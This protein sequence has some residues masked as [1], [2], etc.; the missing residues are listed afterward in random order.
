MSKI[1]WRKVAME[2]RDKLWLLGAAENQRR[3]HCE[4]LLKRELLAMFHAQ[5]IE[6]RSYEEK[7]DGI[8]KEVARRIYE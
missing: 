1:D 2:R 8:C 4:A 3:V 6:R 5:C 7:I